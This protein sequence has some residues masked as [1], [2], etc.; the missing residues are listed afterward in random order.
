MNEQSATPQSN[1]DWGNTAED[2]AKFRPGFPDSFYARL[3][4]TGIIRRGLRVL[5]VGTG[6]G[7][8][9]RNLALRGCEVCALDIAAP[10]MEQAKRLDCEAGVNVRYSLGKAEQT[11]L[12]DA[13]FDAVTAGTC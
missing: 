13:S 11:G 4:S 1:R 8:L 9:A 6:T 3:T 5:D 10:M 12:P 2:Y 7:T